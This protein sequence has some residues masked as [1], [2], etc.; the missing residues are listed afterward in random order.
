VTIP[1]LGEGHGVLEILGHDAMTPECGAVDGR[2]LFGGLG[3]PCGVPRPL[4]GYRKSRGHGNHDAVIGWRH[5]APCDASAGNSV[6]SVGN[7]KLVGKR[8]SGNGRR[9]ARL[10]DLKVF[11][12]HCRELFVD[13]L[14]GRELERQAGVADH[15]GKRLVIGRVKREGILAVLPN[16]PAGR[17]HVG[18]ELS[19]ADAEIMWSGRVHWFDGLDGKHAL[20][21]P[22]GASLRGNLR[23]T[24]SAGGE[25]AEQGEESDARG[26]ADNGGP[27]SAFRR[28]AH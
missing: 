7:V 1:R 15:N 10:A 27:V 18:E 23:R 12:V 19:L 28:R 17:K 11:G 22:L 21:N 3:Q 14:A 8:E 16:A 2:Y 20:W 26:G 6:H 5:V 13:E 24:G 25:E 9:A 4:A